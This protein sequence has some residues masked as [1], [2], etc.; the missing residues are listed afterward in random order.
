MITFSDFS[1]GKENSFM[2]KIFRIFLNLNLFEGDIFDF[3]LRAPNSFHLRDLLTFARGK[4]IFTRT[5]EWFFWVFSMAKNAV[6]FTLFTPKKHGPTRYP[7]QYTIS[8]I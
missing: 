6:F 5:F 3:F 1:I 8:K 7:K 2:V 4:V